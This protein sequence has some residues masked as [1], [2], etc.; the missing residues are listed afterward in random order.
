MR[1]NTGKDHGSSNPGFFGGSDHG[2]TE[3]Y[4]EIARRIREA[5]SAQ[6]VQTSV[7]SPRLAMVH[8]PFELPETGSHQAYTN[9]C[10]ENYVATAAKPPQRVVERVPFRMSSN[11]S[12]RD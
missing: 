5:G 8:D 6:P 11:L 1:G 10:S 3:G 7:E 9:P 4:A 12:R 2:D